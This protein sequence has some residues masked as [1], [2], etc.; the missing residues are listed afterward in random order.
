MICS[1]RCLCILLLINGLA[2]STGMAQTDLGVTVD[3][4]TVSPGEIFELVVQL[5][6]PLPLSNTFWVSESAPSSCQ[7][8]AMELGAGLDAYLAQYPLPPGQCDIAVEPGSAVAFMFFLVAPYESSIYGTEYYRISAL[9]GMTPGE[10][11]L[12]WVMSGDNLGAE[13][14]SSG[15]TTITILDPDTPQD[16]EM[17]RGDF[18]GDGSCNLADAINLLGY[19]YLADQD[20]T[21][22]DAGDIDDSGDLNLADAVNLLGA[23]FLDGY[24]LDDTCQTDATD[25]NLGACDHDNCL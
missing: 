9:A 8:L 19:L 24:D 17:M 23:L 22:L 3:D 13:A 15:E 12:T 6:S 5:D 18:N 25:D 11:T 16:P 1:L 2:T 10:T 4:I 21:C 7:L 20:F 14:F